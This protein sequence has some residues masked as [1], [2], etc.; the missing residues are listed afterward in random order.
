MP[1]LFEALAIARGD[2]RHARMLKAL[3]KVD[4]L[5][6]DDWG[7]SVQALSERRDLLEILEDR[8]GRGPTMVTSAL[9]V[10]HWH[11]AIGDPTLANAILDSL[12]HSA[13]RLKLAG[14]RI[15]RHVAITKPRDQTGQARLHVA[16]GQT[17][18]GEAWLPTMPWNSRPRSVEYALPPPVAHHWCQQRNYQTARPC[19]RA[20]RQ[21]AGRDPDPQ[22]ADAGAGA[23][24][25]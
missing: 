18:R 2:V 21:L 4:L 16:V 22:A 3:A 1:R 13:H 20:A 25:E 12:V 23:A 7:L 19:R 8:H 9:P 10:E 24:G 15:P 17:A 11:E 6:L 14:A 5:V